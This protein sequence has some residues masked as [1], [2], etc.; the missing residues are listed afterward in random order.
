[1]Y[2]SQKKKPHWLSFLNKS[3]SKYNFSFSWD[4]ISFFYEYTGS[5]GLTVQLSPFLG[6]VFGIPPNKI[7]SGVDVVLPSY[8]SIDFGLTPQFHV[9]MCDLAEPQYFKG[10]KFPIIKAHC[11]LQIRLA[12][13]TKIVTQ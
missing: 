8:T 11:L 10:K 13:C 12:L 5:G 9:I 4:G 1:L 3:V 7:F 6:K 2:K